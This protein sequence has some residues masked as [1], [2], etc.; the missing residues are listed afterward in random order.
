MVTGRSFEISYIYNKASPHDKGLSEERKV[1]VQ[2]VRED[3]ESLVD[4]FESW[5]MM[6]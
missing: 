2:S 3:D 4:I 1:F 6:N 5:N